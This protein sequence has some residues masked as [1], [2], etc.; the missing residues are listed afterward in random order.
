M[1]FSGV[2]ANVIRAFLIIVLGLCDPLSQ[3]QDL[4]PEGLNCDDL[5]GVDVNLLLVA[6]LVREWFVEVV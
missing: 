2:Q 4:K 5:V 6:V 1:N 3:L